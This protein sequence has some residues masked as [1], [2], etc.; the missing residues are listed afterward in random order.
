MRVAASAAAVLTVL[1]LSAPA[2]AEPRPAPKP[3]ASEI[4]EPTSR[5]KLPPAKPEAPSE[6]PVS[7]AASKFDCA[8]VKANPKKYI[9]KGKSEVGCLVAPTAALLAAAAP[10]AG[11]SCANGNSYTWIYFRASQCLWGWVRTYQTV[12]ATGGVTGTATLE[13]ATD[14]K[15]GQSLSWTETWYVTMTA[16]TG[17]LASVN[18]LVSK[19]CGSGCTTRN[20][21]TTAQAV[22][23]GKTVTGAIIY[24]AA[25]L[26]R[27]EYAQNYTLTLTNATSDTIAPSTWTAPRPV[28]CDRIL[29]PAGCVL[30]GSTGMTFS[31]S[32][33]ST[34]TVVIGINYYQSR[35][36]DSWGRATLIRHLADTSLQQTSAVSMCSE[37]IAD[38]RV[39]EDTCFLFPFDSNYENGYLQGLAPP[40]C[41]ETRPVLNT[42][43]TTIN[44]LK[45]AVTYTERCFISHV[46]AADVALFKQQLTAWIV[47][48]RILDQDP[49]KVATTA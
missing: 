21:P 46:A 8:K 13:V 36:P 35:Y 39:A 28:R 49:Y 24:A 1:S 42:D 14:L 43:G 12:N 41:A 17:R 7:V 33:A 40:N 34:P 11:I 26:G 4:A 15:A 2:S 18:V 48:N 3:G 47:A 30:P 9:P 19:D 31:A 23:V 5:L 38:S 20:S 22:T 25:P 16:G 32:Q 45:H 29:T 10:P 37:F 44:Y 6:E 27:T